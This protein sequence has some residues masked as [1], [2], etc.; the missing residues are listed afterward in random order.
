MENFGVV[1]IEE[2]VID[3]ARVPENLK[4]LFDKEWNW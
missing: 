1:T 4:V 3:E 2:G